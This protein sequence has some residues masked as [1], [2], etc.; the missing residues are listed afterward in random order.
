MLQWY[1]VTIKNS[2]VLQWYSVTIMVL[3][4][5]G[6]RATMIHGTSVTMIQCYNEKWTS[7]TMI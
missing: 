3:M 1:S 5:Q 2:L 7:V 6:Y 4:L